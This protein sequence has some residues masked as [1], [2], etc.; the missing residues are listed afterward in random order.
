MLQTVPSTHACDQFGPNGRCQSFTVAQTRFADGSWLVVGVTLR[1]DRPEVVGAQW[2]YADRHDRTLGE[3]IACTPR[4]VGALV[5]ML[6]EASLRTQGGR[7]ALTGTKKWQGTFA[8]LGLERCIR[9]EGA[10]ARTRAEIQARAR[11]WYDDF[12]RRTTPAPAAQ[13]S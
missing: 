4:Q 2:R 9:K 13:V 5:P 6:N 10:A 8:K 3:Y 7:V 11:G 1:T 12:V